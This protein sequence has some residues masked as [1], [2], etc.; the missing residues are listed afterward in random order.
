VRWGDEAA[1]E[2]RRRALGSI[3]P[4][5][6]FPGCEEDDPRALTGAAPSILCA[7]HAAA[8]KRRRPFERHHIAGRHNRDATVWLPANWHSVLTFMQQTSWG[9]LRNPRA[10]PLVRAAASIR[11]TRET[12]EVVQSEV[13]GPTEDELLDLDA[14]LNEKLG[15]GWSVEFAAWRES[16]NDAP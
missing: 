7:E 12:I 15:T 10:D 8:D 11:G 2:G 14:F 1:L 16:R 3:E 9:L 6:S 5:C 4:R 13:L